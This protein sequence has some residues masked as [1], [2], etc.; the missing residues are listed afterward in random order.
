MGR[1]IRGIRPHRSRPP[2]KV[3]GEVNCPRCNVTIDT[4]FEVDGTPILVVKCPNCETVFNR[5]MGEI[6][7]DKGKVPTK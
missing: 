4:V 6:L 5:E 2:L 1:R 7:V 3:K